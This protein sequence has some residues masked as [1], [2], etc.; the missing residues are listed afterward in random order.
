MSTVQAKLPVSFDVSLLQSDLA[1]LEAGE[2]IEHFVTQNYQGE[3]SVVPLRGPADANHP[4]R[5]I[6]SDPSCTE[7]SD[8]PFLDKCQYFK[9]VLSWFQCPLQAVRLMKLSAGSYIKEHRDHDLSLEE[10]MARLHIPIITNHQV[11]FRLNQHRVVMNEG[12]CWYLRLSDPHSVANK[13]S[14][15]R[16]HMV[17]DAEV[18]EWLLGKLSFDSQVIV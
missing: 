3:W 16:V 6:Y 1:V 9:A 17:I 4:V 12:E 8:T 18:N 11:Y 2:W 7:F 13:G 5:M 10:G 15:D 14:I